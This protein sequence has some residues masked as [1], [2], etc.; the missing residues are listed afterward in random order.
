[1]RKKKT[2]PYRY[3]G[4]L[5]RGKGPIGVVAKAL[6][7]PTLS[8]KE[9]AAHFLHEGGRSPGPRRISRDGGAAVL[10]RDFKSVDVY[11]RTCG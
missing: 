6:L 3:C 11:R 4:C 7:E 9:N 10:G 1:M 2:A 5:S 8:D